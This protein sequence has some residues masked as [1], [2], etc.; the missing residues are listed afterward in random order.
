M[1]SAMV[2]SIPVYALSEL[3]GKTLTIYVGTCV[4]EETNTKY[5]HVVG[6]EANGR[7]YMLVDKTEPINVHPN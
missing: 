2:D 3:H 1:S 6:R 7:C 4:C 5:T